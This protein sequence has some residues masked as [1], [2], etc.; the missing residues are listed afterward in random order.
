M[1]KPRLAVVSPFIDKR[2][3]TERR[4]AE[5]ISRLAADYEIHV[6]SGRVDDL[7]LEEVVWHRIPEF[8]GPHLLNYLW[9]FAANHLWRWWDARFHGLRYDVVYSP[10]INCLNADA[11]T[12]HVVF[13]E[14]YS[15]VESDLRLRRNPMRSWLRVLHRRLYYRLI[16]AL[17]QR[18]Y[19]RTDLAVGVVS[20]QVAEQLARYFGRRDGTQVIYHGVDSSVFQPAARLRRRAEMRQY[21]GLSDADF[22]LLLVGNGWRNKGLPCLLE[23]MGKLSDLPARLLVAGSDDRVPY[24]LI[25]RQLGIAE[26]VTFLAPSPDVARFYAA[27]DVYVGPSVHDSFAL[28]PAEAMACGLPIITSRNNGGSE[29]VTHGVDGLIFEDPSDS[30]QLA[31]LIR[32]LYEDPEYRRRLGENAV[33]T[34][35]QYTWDR[36]AAQ[37]RAL[38]EQVMRRENGA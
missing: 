11:V 21:F 38:F 3:G 32:Q 26:L 36:N 29:I 8:F 30:E 23:A 37:M 6:Y 13:A 20:R 28:P 12:V 25:A 14:L 4:V 7:N 22:V 1:R 9:W 10:G 34:A 27:C 16:M 18:V 31:Q 5:C 33:L 17:E 24:Q 19:P 15:R 2:H 35:Q